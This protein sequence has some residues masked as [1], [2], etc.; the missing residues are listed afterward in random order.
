MKH[1]IAKTVVDPLMP[2]W[3]S[4]ACGAFTGSPYEIELHAEHANH[5][6]E[7]RSLV[8]RT[9]HA[10]LLVA[11]Q[12]VPV[13]EEDRGLAMREKIATAEEM[14]KA[15]AFEH[16]M[17]DMANEYHCR[18]QRTVMAIRDDARASSARDLEARRER[19]ADARRKG[20]YAGVQACIDMVKKR[21][22]H[23]ELYRC[24][25]ETDRKE[26]RW[27]G[28]GHSPFCKGSA[29][30]THPATFAT[31]DEIFIFLSALLQRGEP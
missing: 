13:Y 29:M 26:G 12:F 24:N 15:L 18:M 4:C 3:R 8:K 19:D 9:C 17:L 31:L 14:L 20:W 1:E 7:L 21:H 6:A 30:A 11:G 10:P 28:D 22:E 27:T 2:E 16:E 23:Y 25:C 5:I